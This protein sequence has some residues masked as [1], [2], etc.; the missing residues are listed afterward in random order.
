MVTFLKIDNGAAALNVATIA[1]FEI[2]DQSEGAGG[3]SFAIDF[4]TV[5]SPRM[6][7]LLEGFTRDEATMA[8]EA[9]L[10][11]IVEATPV[12]GVLD[13]EAITLRFKNSSQS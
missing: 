9:L 12:G 5:A 10:K 6:M 7:P 4:Q 8:L 2:R 11:S 3:D 1:A 13:P